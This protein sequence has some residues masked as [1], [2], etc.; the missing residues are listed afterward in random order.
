MDRTTFQTRLGHGGVLLVVRLDSSTHLDAVAATASESGVDLLEVTSN[1]PGALPWIES[2]VGRH[3]P[4]DIGVGTVVDVE[5]AAA[6]VSAGAAFLVAPNVDPDVL[7]KAAE[8]DVA[9]M[10]GA[11][12]PT[13]VLASHRLG[14]AAT[15]L[16]PVTQL[17]PGYL[18]D[19]RG[20]LP[21]VPLVPI[22]GIDESN[23][24]AYIGAGASGV[25]VG[26]AFVN[27]LSVAAKDWG[28]LGRRLREVVRA[29]ADARSQLN[30]GS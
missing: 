15:K 14:A 7:E 11:L 21:D 25:G 29:V 5:S 27:P 24:G 23:A 16:F 13:E 6:A 22:G 2:N 20:P 4:L 8:Q 1:T 9:C 19:L 10:P 26:A 28:T 17:G 18:E 30:V 12:T 3:P